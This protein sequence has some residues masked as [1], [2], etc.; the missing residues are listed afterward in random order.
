MKDK[1]ILAA[2]ALIGLVGSVHGNA[3]DQES[4]I[5]KLGCKTNSSRTS[6]QFFEQEEVDVQSLTFS[7]QKALDQ[8]ASQVREST[9]EI[10]NPSLLLESLIRN[11]EAPSGLSNWSKMWSKTF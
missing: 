11:N 1:K 4:Q 2:T 6:I 3:I 10:Y 8:L 9:A 7:Q 5:D